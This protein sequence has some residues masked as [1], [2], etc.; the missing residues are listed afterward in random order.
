VAAVLL[1]LLTRV[2]PNK[3]R[4][5]LHCAALGFHYTQFALMFQLAND[6]AGI[7]E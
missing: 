1:F 2:F 5:Y 6:L 3:G 4:E 7:G